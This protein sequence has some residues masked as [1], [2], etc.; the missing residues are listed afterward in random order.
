MRTPRRITG[1]RLRHGGGVVRDRGGLLRSLVAGVAVAAV[2]MAVSMAV[3]GAGVVDGSGAQVSV[4]SPPEPFEDFFEDDPFAFG[5]IEVETSGGEPAVGPHTDPLV[6]GRGPL[7]GVPAGCPAPELAAVVFEGEVIDTDDRSAR[8][9]VSQV[10][11]GDLDELDG[12]VVDDGVLEVRYG[13]EVQ[14]ID[15]GATYLVGA[16]FEPLLGLLYSRVAEPAPMFGGD[17]VVGLAEIDLDCPEF[18]D[19][20]RTL[21]PDGSV[22]ATSV[23]Q[24]LFDHRGQVLTAA[25]LP[26]VVVFTVLFVLAAFATSLRGMFRGLA[27]RSRR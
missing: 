23:V 27:A 8:F 4:S 9:A 3:A 16:Q 14:Y 18:V 6:D 12:G 13:L 20:V 21:W 11:A 24:P 5:E 7:Y 26:F 19:P 10:R 22:V 15:T 25:V 2:S 1:R 17:D